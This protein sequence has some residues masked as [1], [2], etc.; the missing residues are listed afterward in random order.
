MENRTYD[1]EFKMER[2]PMINQIV[3]RCHVGQSERQVIEFVVSKLRN[4]RATFLRMPRMLRKRMM[5]LV[6]ARHRHNRKVY[7]WVS[8]GL[9]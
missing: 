3:D 7:R 4:G 6:V 1:Y 9:K 5:Q 2:I 8:G